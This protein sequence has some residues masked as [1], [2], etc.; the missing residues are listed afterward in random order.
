MKTYK[1]NN[2]DE[3]IDNLKANQSVLISGNKLNGVLVEMSSNG[4]ILRYVRIS[5]NGN[6]FNVFYT[7]K[8]RK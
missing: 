1:Q 8:L 6:K 5:D 4:N 2:T 3:M 7:I